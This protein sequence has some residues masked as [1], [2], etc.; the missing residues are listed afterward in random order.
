MRSADPPE[1]LLLPLTRYLWAEPASEVLWAYKVALNVCGDLRCLAV[2]GGSEIP[3]DGL[4][5]PTVSLGL[6]DEDR[7]PLGD[8]RFYLGLLVVG[9]LRGRRARIVHHVNPFGFGAGVNPLFLL[10][11]AGRRF[12]LGPLFTPAS[13]E[14]G[15]LV[16]LGFRRRERGYPG[17]IVRLISL[18]S[19][20]TLKRADAVI[21]ASEGARR[22]WESKYPFLRSKVSVIV[23]G[24]GLDPDELSPRGPAAQGSRVIVG[25]A[26]NL[27]RRK[28]VDRLVL[29]LGELRDLEWEL[30]IAGDGPERPRIESLAEGL[31]VRGR[32]RFIGRLDRRMMAEFYR[33]IDVYAALDPQ[34]PTEEKASVQE[35]AMA[36]VPFVSGQPLPPGEVRRVEGGLEVNPEDIGS[37]ARALRLLMEDRAL[38]EELGREA[39]WRALRD[40]SDEAISGRIRG[41]Y[42]DLLRHK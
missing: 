34:A 4:P 3:P 42:A 23:N 17:I 5:F 16:R 33:S 13:D 21:Y 22:V 14:P 38:R 1:V 18:L 24:G 31:G 7:T 35:A 41:L 29:A 40:F 9:M 27:I 26:S 32:L 19:A 12:V 2:V 39:R 37:L 8:L 25:V 28:M 6:R 11:K 10:P 15:V 20:A 30:R 36:G